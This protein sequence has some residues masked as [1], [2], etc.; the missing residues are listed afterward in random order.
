MLLPAPP[1]PTMHLPI[2]KNLIVPFRPPNRQRSHPQT[3][4][5]VHLQLSLLPDHRQPRTVAFPLFDQEVAELLDRSR[6]GQGRA[7][8]AIDLLQVWTIPEHR[9]GYGIEIGANDVVL[10]VTMSTGSRMDTDRLD[11]PIQLEVLELTALEHDGVPDVAVD[12]E[13][14]KRAVFEGAERP[15]EVCG[16]RIGDVDDERAQM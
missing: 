1:I 5:R 16:P 13:V 7:P 8:K 4:H 10:E 6:S 2:F 12:D 14:P 11:A 15:L 3:L 9:G